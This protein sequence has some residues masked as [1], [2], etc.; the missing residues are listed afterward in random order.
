MKTAFK[1]SFV[2]DL[3]VIKDESLF[4]RIQQVILEIESIDSPHNILHLTKLKGKGNYFR[5]RV[6]DYRLGIVIEN[7]TVTF[8]RCLNRRDIY[9]YFP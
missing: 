2:R 1:S 5:I 6:G 3:K 4:Q 7:G 8:V 9:H